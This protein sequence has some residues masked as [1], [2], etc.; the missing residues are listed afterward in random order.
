MQTIH[1]TTG[2]IIALDVGERRIGVALC[3][4]Q[5]RLPHPLATLAHTPEIFDTL[6]RLLADQR[7]VAVVVGLP[8]GLDG[9][10]TA[11][12]VYVEQFAGRLKQ[13]IAVPCVFQDEALTSRK[14]EEELLRRG[15]PFAKGDIDAL[16]ATYILED[17]VHEHPEV[18]A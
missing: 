15:K 12:T 13:L 18:L 17:F 4:S 2:S 7:A 14:A 6:M 10:H 5:A 16:S 1:S 11:Q 3:D 9:Q 8:R